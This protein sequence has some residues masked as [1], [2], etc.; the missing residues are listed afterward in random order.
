M[1]QYLRDLEQDVERTRARL[2]DNLTL[3]SSPMAVAEFKANVR[4]EARSTFQALVDDAKGRVAANPAAALAV[5]AGLGWRLL[6]DP[7]I[8]TALIGVGL[9]SLWRTSPAKSPDGDYLATA[10][11]R[12]G[13]QVGAFASSVGERAAEAA[14][15]V[16]DRAGDIAESASEKVKGAAEELAAQA[17]AATDRAASAVGDAASRM[18]AIPETVKG[19]AGDTETQDV[20]LLGAAGLAVAA[21]LG[22]AY[23]RRT[24]DDESKSPF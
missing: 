16:K 17:G 5:G 12:L 7:P 24:A 10:Q 14:D 3:L 1:A 13:E 4:E 20:L 9:F 19:V 22:I 8:A 21:A 2:L 18:R 6:R 15:A 11:T 23:Q